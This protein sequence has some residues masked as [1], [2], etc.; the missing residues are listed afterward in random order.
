MKVV[1]SEVPFY[2]VMKTQHVT[3]DTS[4]ESSPTRHGSPAPQHTQFFTLLYVLL[5]Y[6]RISESN[7]LS[8]PKDHGETL[9]IT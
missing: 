3:S 4:T 7:G 2:Y 1:L 5:V 8:Q 9:T 6:G